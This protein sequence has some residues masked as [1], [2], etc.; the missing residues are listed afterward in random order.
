MR[1]GERLALFAGE[2]VDVLVQIEASSSKAVSGLVIER[3][4]SPP[5]ARTAIHLY[6]SIT[7]GERFDWLV[8]KA[9]ELGVARIVPLIT[10][11]ASVRTGEGN[12]LDRWQRIAIEA[13]E[14]CGRGTVPAIDPPQPF[15]E[16]LEHSPGVRL[17]PYEA[18]GN[19]SPSVQD[20]LNTLIDE[21]F[22]SG[23]ISV[24]IGPEGGFENAEVDAA[25]AAQ[26]MIV[27]LGSRVLR[28]ETAG[29]VASTLA[30]Q[31][32]GELG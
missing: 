17:L 22:A 31:A 32:C 4:P 30:L 15:A 8:E 16:A 2:G 25:R 18:A 7:K 10:S 5:E 24:F 23:A 21:L 12:R 11:R 14:Q 29:L 1:E 28:S 20:A 3:L 13:A 27:T 6:Q 26:A 19:T 9:T